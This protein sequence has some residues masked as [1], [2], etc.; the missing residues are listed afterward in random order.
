M[1]TICKLEMAQA[2]SSPVFGPSAK[3]LK[4]STYNF[5]AVTSFWAAEICS[6]I[7]RQFLFFAKFQNLTKNFF[8]AVRSILPFC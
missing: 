4:Q 3:V 6:L 2:A 1:I 7:R 8:A 5:L